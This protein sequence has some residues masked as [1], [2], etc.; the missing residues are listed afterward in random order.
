M[1]VLSLCG[2]VAGTVGLNNGLGEVAP[3]PAGVTWVFT[4]CFCC[5]YFSRRYRTYAAD[6]L[7]QVSGSLQDRKGKWRVRS[8]SIIPCLNTIAP[9]AMFSLV[10]S[11][12]QLV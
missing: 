4:N 9:L 11:V 8:L 2:L 3:G 10:S 7:Q 6:G 5:S 1:R 12:L